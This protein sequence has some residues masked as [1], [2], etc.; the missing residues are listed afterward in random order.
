M[1]VARMILSCQLEAHRKI[2]SFF[3][4]VC[5]LSLLATGALAQE[6]ARADILVTVTDPDNLVVPEAKVVITHLATRGVHEAFTNLSGSVAFRDLPSGK[7]R[8][9]VQK[10]GFAT[11]VIEEIHLL[12]TEDKNVRVQLEVGAVAE[13]VTV[14]ADLADIDRV[15]TTSGTIRHVVTEER[16]KDVSMMVGTGARSVY[17][18]LPYLVPGLNESYALHGS[19]EGGVSLTVAGVDNNNLLFYGSP[20]TPGANPD[21]VGEITVVTSSKAE[22]GRNLG[23][24]INVEIKSGTPEYHGNYRQWYRTTSLNASRFFDN[25]AGEPKRKRIYNRFGGQIGGPVRIPGLY[26][27]TD[28]TFFFVDYE[29]SRRAEDKRAVFEVPTLAQRTGDFSAFPSSLWPEDP[30]TGSPFPGGIIPADR[31]HPIAQW[32]LDNLIPMPNSGESEYVTGAASR[33]TGHHI[34]FRGDHQLTPRSSLNISY[35]TNLS[36]SISGSTSALYGDIRSFTRN[37]N[38][39]MKHRTDL[40]AGVT[41]T[42]ILGYTRYKYQSFTGAEAL[43][44]YDFNEIGFSGWNP[45]DFRSIGTPKVNIA[46]P[47]R[48]TISSAVTGTPRRSNNWQVKDDMAVVAGAHR[49]KFGFDIRWYILKESCGATNANGYF[50]FS[51][52]NRYGSGDGMADFLLGIPYRFTIDT[53]YEV[54]PRLR[55]HGLYFQDDWRVSRNLTLNLGLRWEYNSPVRDKFNR[56]AA[57]RPGFQSTVFPDALEGLIYYG[58]TDPLLG[59]PLPRGTVIPDRNNFAPRIGLAYSPHAE[60]AFLRLF[61][62]GPGKSAIRLSYGIYYDLTTI[63]GRKD[64][65][66]APPFRWSESPS[67]R[68]IYM[69]GGDFSNP[70]GGPLYIPEPGERA[71]PRRATLSAVDLYFVDAYK[72]HWSFSFQR[73]LPG[74]VIFELSYVGNNAFK[75]HRPRDLNVAVVGPGATPKNSRSREPYQQFTSLKVTESSGWSDYHGLTLEARRSGGWL[76]ISGFYT[77]G[78]A[79]DVSS[80]PYE[81]ASKG[82][83]RS[84]RRHRFSVNYVWYLPHPRWSGILGKIFEGWRISGITRFQSGTP[85]NIYQSLDCQM[86][87]IGG[88]RPDLV[89]E[90][91][92]LDPRPIRTFTLPNGATVTGHFGFDPSVFQIVDPADWTEARNGNLPR[93]YFSGYW[94]KSWDV[95]FAKEI[96]IHESARAEFRLET[97]NLFNHVNFSSPSATVDYSSFGLVRYTGE[98]R[99]LQFRFGIE[100]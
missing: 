38:I 17:D 6:V 74:Q 11:Y 83:A 36:K 29:G 60:N 88:N 85:M 4:V 33:S 48:L 39:V 25:E 67:Y 3:G 18:V 37:Q 76:T 52:Y 32:Y 98:P 72:N 53:A 45:T 2:A 77:Y 21:T 81:F 9:V 22:A 96:T 49:L 64:S 61:T 63:A 14:V 5:L 8:M 10:T 70:F 47:F 54:D 87:G 26:K 58:D 51:K 55:S 28:R 56:V 80:Q 35:V 99:N 78:R 42:F 7:Y 1:S 86:L 16:V 71:F 30:E 15:D 94:S 84:D 73:E 93:N 43:M 19:R 69:A 75:L 65:F 89:G 79:R 20:I 62:G 59:R 12:A 23:G 46:N 68:D 90:F 34:T 13:Q 57:F 97:R 31:I 66:K 91:R 50:Q 27:G 92:L 24:V 95:A 100:F 82:R 40:G 41:N 44:S